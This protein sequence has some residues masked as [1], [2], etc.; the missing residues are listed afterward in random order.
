MKCLNRNIAQF[1]EEVFNFFYTWIF[2]HSFLQLSD[3][4]YSK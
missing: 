2:I 1:I 3:F 4:K